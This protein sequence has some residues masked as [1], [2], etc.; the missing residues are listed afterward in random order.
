MH[1]K[2]M[3]YL[4]DGL[5]IG[6][7][8]ISS[9]TQDVD[10][11]ENEF[12]KCPTHFHKM[13]EPN[14]PALRGRESGLAYLCY[15]GFAV[16]YILDGKVP[17]YSAEVISKAKII[18]GYEIQR[19]P[20]EA[21]H[22]ETRLPAYARATLDDYRQMNRMS[23]NVLFDRGHL[24]PSADLATARSEYESFSLANI[25]PQDST[26]NRGAWAQVEKATRKYVM[27]AQSDVY[28]ITGV[29]FNNRSKIINGIYI[30]SHVWK[31]VFDPVINKGWVHVMPNTT[32]SVVSKPMGLKSFRDLYGIDI[33]NNADSMD[34]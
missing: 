17:M 24:T 13:T 1:I 32:K 19:S 3:K 28:V 30:P 25:I 12:V 2:N 8:C 4:I 16:L 14:I 33:F 34:F 23:G 11:A 22:E 9:L 26:M 10:A 29:L 5:I 20:S 21:F 18:R 27:R 31:G 6:L 15:E 7:L